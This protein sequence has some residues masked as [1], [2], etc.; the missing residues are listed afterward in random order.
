MRKKFK[1]ENSQLKEKTKTQAE[2]SN[3]WHF[4]K[5]IV[6]SENI[7]C[8]W[9]WYQYHHTNISLRTKLLSIAVTSFSTVATKN[10]E[11]KL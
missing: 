5:K 6:F 7:C 10:K 2:N 9:A 11:A 1:A 3:F 8:V 4:F